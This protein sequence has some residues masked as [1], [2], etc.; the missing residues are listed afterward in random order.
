[1]AI[2]VK[3]G[4]M[5]SCLVHN[6]TGICTFSAQTEAQLAHPLSLPLV[7]NNPGD[8]ELSTS[9]SPPLDTKIALRGSPF[10]YVPFLTAMQE[11]I[12]A[13]ALTFLGGSASLLQPLYLS[14]VS[15]KF[16]VRH[17]PYYF[18]PPPYVV[19]CSPSLTR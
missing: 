9:S 18:R 1:M 12:L 16:P 19:T 2:C 13:L 10:F 17:C 5:M 11:P 3:D 8:P 15:R 14:R 7:I 6:V 4:N